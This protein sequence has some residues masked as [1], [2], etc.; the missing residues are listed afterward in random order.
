LTGACIPA[1]AKPQQKVV[2]VML[3]GAAEAQVKTYLARGVL[4]PQG[5]LA[6]LFRRGVHARYLL[7]VDGTFTATSPASLLTDEL[8]DKYKTDHNW[9]WYEEAFNQLIANR[10]LETEGR[11]L[12]AADGNCLLCAEPTADKCYRRMT[13]EFLQQLDSTVQIKHL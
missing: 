6:R 13:A 1:Q 5:G 4:P 11:A 3:R 7:G 9:N 2:L 12:L 10:N 8:L